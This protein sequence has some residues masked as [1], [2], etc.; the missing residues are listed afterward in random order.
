MSKLAPVSPQVHELIRQRWSPRAFDSRPVDEATLRALLEAAQ[1]SPSCHN[2]QP[3]AFIVATRADTEAYADL[4]DCLVPWNQKWAGEADILMLSCAR[5][6]FAKNGEPNRH[7]YH[8][9]GLAAS[10][11]TLQAEASGLAVH[12][13]GGIEVDKA[14]ATYKIPEDWDPVAGLAIGYAGDPASLP[15]DLRGMEGGERSRKALSE[16][17]FRGAWGTA[18]L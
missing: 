9:V 8:D 3:W 13:M 15:E 4:L 1:W 11:M 5:T 12:Q 10:Q 16:M 14:R 18:F 17:A 2:E 7:A 6:V